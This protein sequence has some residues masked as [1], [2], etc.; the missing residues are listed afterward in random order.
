MIFLIT[1]PKLLSCTYV[2]PVDP[3][4]LIE[5]DIVSPPPVVAT[6]TPPSL[7]YPGSIVK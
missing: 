3:T 2:P 7:A 1:L 6:P 4:P 5:Y